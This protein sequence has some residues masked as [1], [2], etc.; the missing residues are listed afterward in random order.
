MDF[1]VRDKGVVDGLETT[2]AQ[3]LKFV[4]RFGHCCNG[5]CLR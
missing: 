4:P 5:S 3:R 1:V 2:A